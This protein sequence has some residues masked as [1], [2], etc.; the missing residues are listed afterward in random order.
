MDVNGIVC[1]GFTDSYSVLTLGRKGCLKDSELYKSALFA[2]QVSLLENRVSSEYS[3]VTDE[4]FD[5]FSQKMQSC[6]GCCGVDSGNDTDREP[7]QL[8]CPICFNVVGFTDDPQNDGL[9]ADP[10]SDI[11][12]TRDN[13]VFDPFFELVGQ[14]SADGGPGGDFNYR[15]ATYITNPSSQYY[16]MV[17]ISITEFPAGFPSKIQIWD[18]NQTPTPTLEGDFSLGNTTA[19]EAIF[20]PIA[21]DYVNDRIYMTTGLAK[22]IYYLDLASG[23]YTLVGTIGSWGG[24]TTIQGYGV[25][26][27]PVTNKRYIYASGPFIYPPDRGVIGILSPSDVLEN[28]F[29]FD[30]IY[31]T[32]DPTI[33]NEFAS[34]AG[35]VFDS[36]GYAYTITSPNATDYVVPFTQRDIVKLDPVTNEVVAI[37]NYDNTQTWLPYNTSNSINQSVM[38]YY[39]GSGLIQGEKILVAYRNYG[40]SPGQT[41]FGNSF[42]S[43]PGTVTRLVAFDTQAPYSSSVILEIPDTLIPDAYRF[44]YNYQYNKIFITTEGPNNIYAVTPNLDI[45]YTEVLPYSGGGL[46]QAFDLPESNRIL[47]INAQPNPNDN[48]FVIEPILR[49]PEGRMYVLNEG[50]YEFEDNEWSPMIQS[51]TFTQSGDQW[52]VTALFN[53]SVNSAKLQYTYNLTD[54]FDLEDVTGDLF[55][56]PTEWANGILFV[57]DSDQDIWFRVVISTNDDCLIYG[58]IYPEPPP[59]TEFEA[60]NTNVYRYNDV[61]FTDLSVGVPT[62]WNW[63]FEGG[64]PSTSTVENPTPIMWENA[65]VYDVSLSATNSNGTR[66][67]TKNNYITVSDGKLLNF[68]LDSQVAYSLRLINVTYSGPCIRV[69]RDSD[70]TEQDIPFANG[71]LDLQALS[72]FCGTDNGYVVYWYD[73]S[74]NG[75]DLFNLTFAEQPQIFSLGLPLLENGKPCIIFDGSND[76]MNMLTSVVL[77]SMSVLVVAS[78]TL[79]TGIRPLIGT[80]LANQI[81]PFSNVAGGVFGVVANSSND[82]FTVSGGASQSLLT[83]YRN[84]TGSAKSAYRNGT[85]LSFFISGITNQIGTYTAMAG[86]TGAN[87]FGGKVQEVVMWNGSNATKNNVIQNDVNDYYNIY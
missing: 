9:Y 86:A 81:T 41:P 77:T 62:S 78:Q 66:S 19:S 42:P 85:Q 69:R 2:Y 49:C 23:T 20:G 79:N 15:S 18:P 24:T 87:R 57:V 22:Q 10:D 44:H 70:N 63:T 21:Y 73:Q 29:P 3:C 43:F 30:P 75:N 33:D 26:I 52:N 34:T 25:A 38:Q 55:H 8:V 11:I 31:T 53:D 64:T 7:S 27:N 84:S 59:L 50:T 35:F 74:G 14:G 83:Y 36:D 76:N 1:C 40:P 5:S 6:C 4:V 17:A 65:G 72:S 45:V 32:P 82:L 47:F 80:S 16:G 13:G 71:E 61:S 67:L 51:Q 58:E 37:L 12:V 68:I 28:A 39:D 56:D 54:Y 46:Y 60:D 48:I